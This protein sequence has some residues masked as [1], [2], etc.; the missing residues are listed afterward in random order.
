[1]KATFIEKKRIFC[2]EDTGRSGF[3]GG[4]RITTYVMKQLSHHS[5][6]TE[7]TVFDRG[8]NIVCDE[9]FK[10][11][12]IK[13]IPLSKNKPYL[14]L[15]R[16]LFF[17][18]AFSIR[19][20]RVQT[21]CYTPTR[22]PSAIIGFSK[23]IG[24]VNNLKCV[25]HEHM[26]APRN[27]FI[28]YLYK[29][30]TSSSEFIIYS[31]KYCKATYKRNNLEKS[32]PK[33]FGGIVA[34]DIK[35]SANTDSLAKST[36]QLCKSRAENKSRKYLSL[37]YTGRI[38]KEKGIFELVN[39]FKSEFGKCLNSKSKDIHLFISGPGSIEQIKKLNLLINGSN[40][41]HYLG[42]IDVSKDFY[43]IFD[44]GIVPSWNYS[45]SLGLSA[46]ELCFH[47]GKALIT[48]QGKAFDPLYKIKGVVKLNKNTSLRTQIELLYDSP[49]IAP[50]SIKKITGPSILDMNIF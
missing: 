33:I 25:V 26:V 37:I 5:Q 29:F 40:N 2:F 35:D 31:S 9:F 13:Y 38:N 21:I 44:I 49:P 39:Y 16:W 36:N 10:K 27:K 7:I 20:N 6:S 45:E 1:M 46:L 14:S 3:A 4:Q 42:V 23:R 50:E 17:C 24:L 22:I 41:I 19:K 12:S 48:C 18:F 11:Y 15:L 30:L 47:V 34:I 43:K 32:I 28:F 8:Y